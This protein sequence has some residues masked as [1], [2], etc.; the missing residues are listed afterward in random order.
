MFPDAGRRPVSR[1]GYSIAAYLFGLIG[2]LSAGCD[3]RGVSAETHAWQCKQKECVVR[4]TLSNEAAVARTVSYVVRAHRVESAVPGGKARR[5]VVV[6]AVE[7]AAE[8]GGAQRREFTQTVR[9]IAR[10]SQIVVRVRNKKH[11]S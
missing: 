2:V 11:G 3:G 1:T 8:L 7:G 6:G 4:F 9:V 5:D 10:P